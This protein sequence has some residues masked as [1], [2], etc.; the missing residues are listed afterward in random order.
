M[1]PAHSPL[2]EGAANSTLAP[3]AFIV[4]TWNAGAAASVGS[5]VVDDT[6][7]IFVPFIRLWM[8]LR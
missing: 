5:I 7:V 2:G 8:A 4:V 3:L 6:I 1:I